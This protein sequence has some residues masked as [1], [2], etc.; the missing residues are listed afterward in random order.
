M[1]EKNIDLSKLVGFEQVEA[2]ASVDFTGEVFGARLGAKRGG[3]AGATPVDLSK[4]VGF[5][6]VASVDFQ[7]EAFG[8][9]VGA[10]RGGEASEP[11]ADKQD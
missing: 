10:K 7:D 4:L 9:R 6:Q 2:G 1:I 8:A 3:E 5:D 11:A